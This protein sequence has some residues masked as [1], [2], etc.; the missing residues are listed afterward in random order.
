MTDLGGYCV[1]TLGSYS[2]AQ[3]ICIVM[4]TAENAEYEL[5]NSLL[6]FAGE[7]YSVTVIK[8]QGS[9]VG[10]LP[11]TL[12]DSY[13]EISLALA[14]D[15]KILNS[16]GAYADAD[17]SYDL[18]LTKSELRAPVSAGEQVGFY[19]VRSGNDIVACIP[20]VTAQ[21]AERNLILGAIDD[22]KNTL[23]ARSTIASIAFFCVSFVLFIIFI[24]IRKHRKRKKAVYARGRYR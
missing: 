22:M 4:N 14:E 6:S 24:M 3:Y 23:S 16:S 8:E 21:S 13:S 10:K 2:G 9:I 7:N 18:V 12:S 15:A 19:V 20:V 17:L 5:A 11:I 1:A